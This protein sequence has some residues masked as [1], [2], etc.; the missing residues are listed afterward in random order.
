MFFPAWGQE[1]LREGLGRWLSSLG[2]GVQVRRPGPGPCPA[3]FDV[4]EPF[5][6]DL[7]IG[8]QHQQDRFFFNLIFW[9]VFLFRYL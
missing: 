4:F 7:V 3:I 1:E 9:E 8:R 5:I 2:S 6:Q